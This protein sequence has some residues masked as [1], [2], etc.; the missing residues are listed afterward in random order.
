MDIG[1]ILAKI[2]NNTYSSRQEL[3]RDLASLGLSGSELESIKKSALENYEKIKSNINAT[4]FTEGAKT[5]LEGGV[6]TAKLVGQS[7][8]LYK[9]AADQRNNRDFIDLNTVQK[10]SD[11]TKSL[12]LKG[13]DIIDAFS[14]GVDAIN[15][16]VGNYFDREAKTLTKLNGEIGLAGSLAKSLG[17]TLNLEVLPATE[18]LGVG[19]DDLVD[20]IKV[21]VQNSEKFNLYQDETLINAIKISKAY[22]SSS[23]YI[24]ANFESFRN[25]GINL[26]DMTEDIEEAGKKSLSQGLLAK[27]TTKTLTENIEKLNQFGFKNGTEGLTKM[28]MQA[29]SL[30][31]KLDEVFKIADGLFEP[32]K[33]IEMSANLQVLGGAYG[34]LADPIKLMYD[35]TNDVGS[36]QD[37][38]L[39]AARGLATY[40]AEQGR[41][42]VTGANLRRAKSMADALGMS[43]SELT[44]AAIKG[45]VQMQALSEIEVFNFKDEDQKQF[46]ANLATMKDGVVGFDISKDMASKLGIKEGFVSLR[47]LTDDKMKSLISMQEEI[48]TKT[49]EQLIRDQFTVATQS[50]NALNSIAYN[51][52]NFL[53]KSLK[54]SDMAKYMEKFAGGA[55][56]LAKMNEEQLK[57]V[58]NKA[59]S[60]MLENEMFKG[61]YDKAKLI[62]KPIVEAAQPTLQTVANF[63]RDIGLIPK[64][65]TPDKVVMNIKLDLNSNNPQM[66]QMFVNE[67]QNNPAAKKLL[68]D[69]IFTNERNF[70]T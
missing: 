46:V 43:M 31:F 61:V 23:D 63:S 32:E 21:M 70:V 59:F 19:F 34:D 6:T 49:P 47:E 33:A 16:L 66:A 2:T 60:K 36:L 52:S 57:E 62:G 45:Q 35:A 11:M 65:T 18:L 41:F 13:A 10:L 22:A 5:L 8:L 48:A 12:I 27:N 4:T 29:Q 20:S 1:D 3:E 56:E 53:G 17:N 69:S 9:S 67:V 25:V 58:G 37:S 42:E 51:I 7:Y 55:T 44:S 30:K 54:D 28:V 68:F 26:V 38:I 24:M 64:S 40:N 15:S 14:I 50:L 39:G